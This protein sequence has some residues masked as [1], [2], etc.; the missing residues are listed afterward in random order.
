MRPEM[1]S[2]ISRN[3]RTVFT[4]PTMLKPLSSWL[5]A[6]VMG[7]TPRHQVA[8]G[9]SI[10][11]WLNFSEYHAYT[12]LSGILPDEAAF[13]RRVVMEAGRDSSVVF[14]VGANIGI[15]T[16]FL[17]S[18]AKVVHSFEAVPETFCRLKANVA[19]NS[20]GERCNLNCFALGKASGFATFKCDSHAP[21]WNR[22]ARDQPE[23][24]DLPG[25]SFQQVV[26]VSL[27]G[28]C[29]QLGIEEI[30]FMK[31]DV[32]G[33]EPLILEG[34]AKLLKAKRISTILVEVSPGNLQEAGF[35]PASLYDMI[36]GFAYRPYSLAAGG[37]LGSALNVDDFCAASS[38]NVI[39]VPA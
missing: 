33:M 13:M 5:A 39:L 28:Y 32:E 1:V 14:D 18:M 38:I 31:I 7:R 12:T 37:V 19:A 25:I 29:E 9:V 26:V 30:A 20:L 3:V 36:T 24:E 16:C 35:S 21:G 22:I 27:D 23:D 17:G 34:G 11:G 15:F 8:P 2:K 4:N 6:R 10:G